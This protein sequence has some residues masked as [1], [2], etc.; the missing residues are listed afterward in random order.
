MPHLLVIGSSSIDTLHFK[1]QTEKLA[2]GAGLY[3]ALSAR[4]SSCK[5]SMYGPRPHQMPESLKR[6]EEQLEAWL[7][8]IVKLD[9][10]PHFE[11]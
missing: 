11:I 5:V 3:T 8:P 4:R 10:I 9:N 1:N 7:G 2:G 6:L